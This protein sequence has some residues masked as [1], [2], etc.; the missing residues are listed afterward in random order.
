MSRP[1]ETRGFRLGELLEPLKARA[2]VEGTTQTEI[3]KKA[4]NEYLARPLAGLLIEKKH[5]VGNTWGNV[6]WG[7]LLDPLERRAI[8]ERTSSSEIA[9][10]AV[11]L[12]LG[13]GELPEVRQFAVELRKCHVD[14]AKIGGNLNQIAMVFNADKVLREKDLG[15]VHIALIDE[16][17]KMADFYKRLEKELERRIP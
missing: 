7:R 5:G 6:R 13:N 17:K 4:L 1:N 10:R 12:Y 3:I 15:Q 11:R 8:Q 16:F 14:I 9:R 2:E